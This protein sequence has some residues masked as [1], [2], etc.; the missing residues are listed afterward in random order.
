MKNQI[1]P[2]D[3]LNRIEKTIDEK[4][5]IFEDRIAIKSKNSSD[6]LEEIIRIKRK[7][8]GEEDGRHK[9]K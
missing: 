6:A 8:Y 9:R 4:Q 1:Q 5:E 7:V 2:Q 3:I